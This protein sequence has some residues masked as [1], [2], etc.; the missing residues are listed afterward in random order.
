MAA[1]KVGFT[2][3]QIWHVRRNWLGLGSTVSS[4]LFFYHLMLILNL[5]SSG[6]HTLGASKKAWFWALVPSS[7]NLKAG[8]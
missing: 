1:H 2:P 6:A 8:H 5:A 7:G 4:P 3:R